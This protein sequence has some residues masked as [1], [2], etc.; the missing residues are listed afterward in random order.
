MSVTI[1]FSV[2]E[3]VAVDPARR[4]ALFASAVAVIKAHA[5]FA[6]WQYQGTVGSSD[7]PWSR[8]FRERKVGHRWMIQ[9]RVAFVFAMFERSGQL[10]ETWVRISDARNRVAAREDV[11]GLLHKLNRDVYD[12]RIEIF[13]EALFAGNE[14]DSLED[15]F[16]SDAALRARVSGTLE[17]LGW[18]TDDDI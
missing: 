6:G 12:G 13:D 10:P 16:E 17:S 8:S 5:A 4:R 15:L 7:A 1:S 2:R 14:P 11:L 3:E 9:R 18:D